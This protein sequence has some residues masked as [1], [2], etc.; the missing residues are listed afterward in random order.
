MQFID[1]GVVAFVAF[2]HDWTM[3]AVWGAGALHVD[4]HMVPIVR[5]AT[6]VHCQLMK[7]GGS[8]GSHLCVP[9]QLWP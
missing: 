9:S 8:S 2:R 4:S 6:R 5:S 7:V 3:K 1:Q